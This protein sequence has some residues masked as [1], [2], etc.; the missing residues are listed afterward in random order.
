M[1]DEVAPGQN[2]H[3]AV[4]TLRNLRNL[5]GA[6]RQT[7]LQ[8]SETWQK[9][10]GHFLPVSRM[11][12][13]IALRIKYFKPFIES[14]ACSS[15]CMGIG[16]P[17]SCMSTASHPMPYLLPGQSPLCEFHC[18]SGCLPGNLTKG[19]MHAATTHIIA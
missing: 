17:K 6:T 3:G 11:K 8:V 16:T 1:I 7:D 4:D 2:A 19:C 13:L 15:L 18:A 10:V 14:L 9:F 5:I 12:S